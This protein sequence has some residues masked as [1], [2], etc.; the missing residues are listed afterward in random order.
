[1]KIIKIFPDG[2]GKVIGLQPGD[3]LLK[4]NGKRVQDEIDYK[5]RIT[6]EKLILDFEI[7]GQIEQVE[8]EK[9]YDDDLGVEFE[10]IK[11]RSCANDCVFCFVDQNPPNMREGMYF[12]DGDFRMSYLQG[13]WLC[14]IMLRLRLTLLLTAEFL[15]QISH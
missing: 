13:H 14:R 8:V 6:E 3:R 7:K 4:I 12:R 1:M 2:L 15:M 5:F 11:I 10:E 9:E